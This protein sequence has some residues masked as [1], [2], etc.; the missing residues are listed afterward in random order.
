MTRIPNV[1]GA[2]GTVTKGLVLELENKRVSGD[3][4]D[5]RII[6]ISQNTEKSPR[7]MLS[8]KLQ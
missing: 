6:K 4:L 7:D 2:V 8:L 5:H 1:I 3:S